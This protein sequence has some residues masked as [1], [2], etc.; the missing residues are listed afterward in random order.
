[1][2]G[3]ST[4]FAL[5][6]RA[7]LLCWGPKG[8]R[9]YLRTE[10]PR[11]DYPNGYR[12]ELLPPRRR[13]AS[14]SRE[15]LVVS[16]AQRRRRPRAAVTWTHNTN[17]SDPARR[18]FAGRQRETGEVPMRALI[19]WSF[20]VLALAG[21]GGGGP[22]GDLE[23]H[24]ARMSDAVEDALWEYS[25]D[26]SIAPDTLIKA[27]EL[28]LTDSSMLDL[29]HFRCSKREDSAPTVELCDADGDYKW[30]REVSS[31]P[32]R[33][34]DAATIAVQTA[35]HAGETTYSLK[36]ACDFAADCEDNLRFNLIDPMMVP[37][38]SEADCAR[39][40]TQLAEA[41]A[42]S[43]A[44]EV[45]QAAREQL[46]R[47][48]PVE[49]REE[50]RARLGVVNLLAYGTADLGNRIAA[51]GWLRLDKDLGM[52]LRYFRCENAAE[53]RAA[54]AEACRTREP[55]PNP[56]Q[57]YFALPA[58]ELGRLTIDVLADPN[59]Q[60]TLECAE[61]RPCFNVQ[62]IF[63]R[64]Q[65]YTAPPIDLFAVNCTSAADC[66]AIAQGMRDI[67][68][69]AATETPQT[70]I[71]PSLEEEYS[72]DAETLTLDDWQ[73]NDDSA[74][75]FDPFRKIDRAA[76]APVERA[77]NEDI[78]LGVADDG[79]E[80]FAIGAELS[81]GQFNVDVSYDLCE[82]EGLSGV[83]RCR[84]GDAPTSVWREMFEPKRIAPDSLT[85]GSMQLGAALSYG[86][87][88]AE[89]CITSEDGDQMQRSW[90]PCSDART[91]ER[92]ATNFRTFL[93]MFDTQ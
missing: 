72:I 89:K 52:F 24:V 56:L 70:P 51:S 41:V 9:A 21:C 6:A 18:A 11:A 34:I 17:N 44:T 12:I 20:V 55:Y 45:R 58:A 42:Q 39:L 46:L 28:V 4:A 23:Q 31:W 48:E 62:T 32:L 15:T 19:G 76:L 2:P 91:C 5:R 49:D 37:C 50:A 61:Q 68:A 69:Y 25:N 53:D 3:T 64:A 87:K 16:A 90:L 71:E 54:A 66:A 82:A 7:R 67:V 78:R 10:V 29:R 75:F 65:S 40:A 86:C 85:V 33:Q 13:A 38:V 35:Q 22:I 88:D 47:A 92:L 84:G 57:V 93:R 74:D 73:L 43:R 79:D 1:M 26:S 59:R 30:E 80:F 81:V 14:E 8:R 27:Y 36:F 83:Q 63:D 60:V 77:I